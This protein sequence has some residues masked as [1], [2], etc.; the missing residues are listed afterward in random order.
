[1]K[2]VLLTIFLILGLCC[3]GKR[4]GLDNPSKTFLKMTMDIDYNFGTDADFEKRIYP[5][6]Q[7]PI[8]DEFGNDTKTM[9]GL[10]LEALE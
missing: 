9:Q 2:K 3:C 8:V 7:E 10:T 5:K 4:G 6:P 1:M